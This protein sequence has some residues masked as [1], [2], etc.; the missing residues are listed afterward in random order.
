MC[1]RVTMN[2][3][4]RSIFVYRVRVGIGFVLDLVLVS[5]FVRT[6]SR[7]H[8]TSSRSAELDLVKNG[9]S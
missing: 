5:M 7:H 8:E 4:S 3:S 2:T 9:D 1:S 6:L